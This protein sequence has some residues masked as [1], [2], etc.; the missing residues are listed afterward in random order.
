M[1]KTKSK[2]QNAGNT[3]QQQKEP[4]TKN[5]KQKMIPTKPDVEHILEKIPEAHINRRKDGYI[6]FY[7]AECYIKNMT[8]GVQFRESISGAPTGKLTRI[9]TPEQMAN[10]IDTIK[11]RTKYYTPMSKPVSKVDPDADIG[12]VIKIATKDKIKKHKR[13]GESY[14][15]FFNRIFS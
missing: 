6:K 4:I 13:P 2:N 15:K 3:K 14:D 12:L 11:N 7:E 10:I 9:E 1:V 5:G 8:Y